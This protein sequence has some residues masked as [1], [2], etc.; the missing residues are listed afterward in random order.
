MTSFIYLTKKGGLSVHQ[1]K[2]RFQMRISPETDQKMKRAISL[3]NCRSQNEFVEQA[4]NFYCE[5][6]TVKDCS[7]ILPPIF[8][9]TMKGSLEDTENRIARLLF[10]Q[11]VEL[12]IMMHILASE[13]DIDPASVDNL[14]AKCIRDVKKTNGAISL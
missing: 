5:Y 10:K 8:L 9:S 2:V 14:R 7:R 4:L 6:L 1:E 3:A 11:T 12:S 13:L